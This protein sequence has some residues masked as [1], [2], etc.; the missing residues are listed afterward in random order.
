MFHVEH[1]LDNIFYIRNN[2]SLRIEDKLLKDL[3]LLSE[4]I[5]PRGTF[6]IS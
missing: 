6:L 3:F 4:Y 2:H 5:V 1:Y